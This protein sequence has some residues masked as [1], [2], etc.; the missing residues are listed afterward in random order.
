MPA[1][2]TW[3]LL[4]LFV[5]APS[6]GLNDANCLAYPRSSDEGANMR[7]ALLACGL[8]ILVGGCTAKAAS[9]ATAAPP[10]GRYE[11]VHSPHVQAD[12]Q[13]LDTYTGQTWVLESAKDGTYV[14]G[15]V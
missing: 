7:K 4:A 1:P 15:R 11:I 6:K 5:Q 9:T 14:W 12:T 8:L 2:L 3:V 10:A 13:L